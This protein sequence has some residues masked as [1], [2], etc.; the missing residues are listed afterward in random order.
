[1]EHEEFERRLRA[2]DPARHLE[3]QSES[4]LHELAIGA[5]AA[6]PNSAHPRPH[7]QRT[8]RRALAAAAVVG[9][10]A[11]PSLQG[12]MTAGDQPPTLRLGGLASQSGGAL[13]SAN[14]DM[15]MTGS[16]SKMGMSMWWGGFT[17]VA[18]TTLSTQGSSAEAY[19]M[20][21]W[22]NAEKVIYAV[23]DLFG[24]AR[25]TENEDGWWSTVQQ[26]YKE[27]P[28]EEVWGNTGDW[29]SVGYYNSGVD[30]WRECWDR[31]MSDTTSSGD[32][33]TEPDYCEP[34]KPKNLPTN[35]E[36]QLKLKQIMTDLDIST[37]GLEFD[38]QRDDYY[39]WVYATKMI[40]GSRS[41]LNWYLSLVDNSVVHNFGGSLADMKSVGTY[42][43]ISPA[44][45]LDRANAQTDKWWQQMSEA[46]QSSEEPMPVET[47]SS[48]AGNSGSGTSDG[49]GTSEPG[50]PG[51]DVTIQPIEPDDPIGPMPT[52]EPTVVHVTKVTLGMQLFN[53]VDGKSLW[54]PTYEFWGYTDDNPGE[55]YQYGTVVA[56]VDSQID[57]TE[58]YNA[59][60]GI[61][62]AS[63]TVVR[64]GVTE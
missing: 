27:Y 8:W 1:M 11:A 54:L 34:A 49:S 44:A 25:P 35:A 18:D 42:D 12:A 59:M 31:P 45:A 22:A 61:G 33:V 23:A 26:E 64:S 46:N 57:L 2:A 51:D 28:T 24:V 4:E 39:V 63:D 5:I 6:E 29:A 37:T 14:G 58:F 3:P 55:E 47:G 40:D 32:V 21:S 36:A 60:Y 19:E 7:R 9:L 13:E 52:W 48:D 43:L 56:V 20:V 16:D 38:I 30:P 17:Y 41:P 50:V 53:T 15:D 10:F 62:M